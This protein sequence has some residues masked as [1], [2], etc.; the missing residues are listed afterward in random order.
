M[1]GEGGFGKVYLADYGARN[2]AAK[3]MIT[4]GSDSAGSTVRLDDDCRTD[5]GADDD[6]QQRKAT[7]REL[8]AMVRLRSPYTVHV[9]GAITS[10]KERFII[11]ME[12]LAG[13]DLRAFL[14]RQADPVPHD[15]ARRIVGDVCAGMEFLHS[16]E[17]VHGDLKSANVLLDGLGR[18][19]VSLDV[20]V[21]DMQNHCGYH[22]GQ[23]IQ[24]HPTW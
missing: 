10:D 11:V 22:G 6:D 16:R 4:N 17:T 20:C 15:C 19:K 1:L 5:G 18:A 7:M 13:G 12:L 3:V 9:Y 2:V 21:V 14:K 8:Q 23:V 24:I